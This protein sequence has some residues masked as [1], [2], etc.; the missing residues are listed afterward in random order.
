MHPAAN[1]AP[2]RRHWITLA[3]IGAVGGLLSGALGVGGGIL[4]VPL[5]IG[6]ARMDDRRAST[7]SL[8]AIVPT[9]LAG[10]LTYLARGQAD[11][12]LGAIL[13]V[14][15]VAGSWLGTWL[16]HRTPLPRLRWMFV[17]LLVLV[18]VRMVLTVPTRGAALEL[19]PAAG[20]ALVAVGVFMGVTSGLFGI[21]GGLVLVPALVLLFGVD[22]L[23]AQGT[24]LLVMLPTAAT[25]TLANLR[26]GRVDARE[27]AVVGLTATATSFAGV[28]IAFAVPARAA[29]I[30]FAVL[31]L[32]AAAQLAH[33]ALRRP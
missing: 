8:A 31:V 1:T 3:A 25:G 21:G 15:G 22:N 20:L 30:V 5:L 28:A 26:T 24:S 9:A 33:R 27:G 12:T 32:V 14:G 4:M 17:G 10:S 16:L 13:A 29:T 23:L 2:G 7:T 18:A 11:L 19:T 6:L